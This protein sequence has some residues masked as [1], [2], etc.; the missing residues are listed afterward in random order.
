M[1]RSPVFLKNI[2]SI[3]YFITLHWGIV[4]MKTRKRKN[5]NVLKF[6]LVMN[7]KQLFWIFSQ[8]TLIRELPLQQFNSP[9]HTSQNIFIGWQWIR[10]PEVPVPP[11]LRGRVLRWWDVVCNTV[12]RCDGDPPDHY[13]WGAVPNGWPLTL[14]TV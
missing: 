10:W 6:R 4:Q 12:T 7:L 2:N 9:I 13:V 11:L 14:S 5:Q 8:I 3:L 1:K